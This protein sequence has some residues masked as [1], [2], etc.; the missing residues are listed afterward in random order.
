MNTMKVA[1]LAMIAAVAIGAV[2]QIPSKEVRTSEGYRVRLWPDG[3]VSV[4]AIPSN[5]HFR[6]FTKQDLQKM[7]ELFKP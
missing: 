3:K 5:N 7:L 6:Y 4:D 1:F 2:D